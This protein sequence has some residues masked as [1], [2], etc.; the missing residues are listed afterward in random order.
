MKSHIQSVYVTTGKDLYNCSVLYKNSNG[1]V[2]KSYKKKDSVPNK[3]LLFIEKS[4]D[5]K[6]RNYNG[7]H[8]DYYG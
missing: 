3:V 5:H 6:V 1:I 4:T 8:F 2:E 7:L